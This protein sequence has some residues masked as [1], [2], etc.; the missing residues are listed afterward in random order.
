MRTV[1]DVSKLTGVSIRTLHY[2]DKIGLL[3]PA[4]VTEAKY[5]LYDDTDLERLQLILLYRELQF[6]LKEIK[7][8]LNSS[9]FD[10]NLALDQQI[11]LLKMR[12]E[13]LE[14]LIDLAC[15]I[16]KTGVSKLDFTAFDTSKMDEYAAQAKAA[17]GHTTAYGEFEKKS[18]NRTEK[19]EQEIASKLMSLFKE[20]GE[21]TSLGISSQP[22]Q[23]QVK[24][25]Q[26]F[27]TEHYYTCT[28]EILKELGAMYSCGGE[29]TENIDKAGGKGTADFASQ[30]IAYYCKS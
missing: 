18:K 12:K 16:K 26:D 2:Y 4:Q 23:M 20:F 13:H 6:P 19:E 3:H 30:A 8:I 28:S 7:S 27:I 9:D 1:H 25:L 22:V 11:N 24:K 5:R 14:N 15:E 29:M 17:Y 10:R 21:M